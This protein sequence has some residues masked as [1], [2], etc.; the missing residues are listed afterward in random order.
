MNALDIAVIAVILLSGL[1]AFSRGFVREGLSIASWIGAS[2]AAVYA[3]EPGIRIAKGLKLPELV[4]QGAAILLPFIVA[5]VLLSI[6]TNFIAHRVRHSALSSVDRTL[7]LV[8]GLARGVLL[9]CL[10][11]IGFTIVWPPDQKD[12]P[13]LLAQSRTLPLVEA[14]AAALRQLVPPPYRDKATTTVKNVQ[15]ATQT[16]VE[17][18]IGAYSRPRT[19]GPAAPAPTYSPSDQRDLDRLIQQ[20]NSH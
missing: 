5:L 6:V 20:E 18:A 15:R 14:G 12:Q 16:E 7:G 19:P 10:A 13:E 17:N 4:A 3:Y 11:Y 8:F 1:F 2:A 9:V